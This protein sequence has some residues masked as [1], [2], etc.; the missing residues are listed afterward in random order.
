M[1]AESIGKR[2]KNKLTFWQKWGRGWRVIGRIWVFLFIIRLLILPLEGIGVLLGSLADNFEEYENIRGIA[3]FVIIV[4]CVIY[5]PFAFY[6]AADT[7]GEFGHKKSIKERR[8]ENRAKR[9]EERKKKAYEEWLEIEK[10][11][12][13]VCS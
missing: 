13:G 6:Y 12:D 10:K 5:L 4:L 9:L 7:I 2:K 11:E 8:A 1:T 3:V